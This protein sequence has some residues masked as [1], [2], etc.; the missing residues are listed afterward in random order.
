MRAEAV[1][2]VK[3]VFSLLDA[4]GNG[5]LEAEDFD[6]MSSRVTA[7]AHGSGAPAKEAMR[8][9]FQRYWTTLK[10][11]LDANRDGRVSFDEYVGCVLSP[12]RFDATIGEF[13]EALSAL[14]DP[15]GDGRI[16]RALFTDLMLAIGFS[17]ANIDALFNAFG[18]DKDDRITVPTWSEGIKEY[19]APNRAGI[20]GDH[21]VAGVPS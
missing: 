12:E 15:D 6:L 20:P 18:P 5:Y 3:L 21:L 4:D 10:T 11:E 9:A 2:R 16:E 8:L 1:S 17:P 19:Y 14:G 7:A 13:A